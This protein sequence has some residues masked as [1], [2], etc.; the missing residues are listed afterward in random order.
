MWI[1]CG[2]RSEQTLEVAQLG[3]R[4]L[5][6]MLEKC[7]AEVKHQ[8]ELKLWLHELLAHGRLLHAMIN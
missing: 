7:L 8:G 6:E 2:L 3:H 1:C 5:A 4:D